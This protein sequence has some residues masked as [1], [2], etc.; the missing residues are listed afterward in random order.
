[1]M[2]TV[3]IESGFV[4]VMIAIYKPC[5]TAISAMLV[6]D[7]GLIHEHH[8]FMENGVC[9]CVLGSHHKVLLRE[10]EFCTEPVA[11]AT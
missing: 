6:V 11:I 8:W 7:D 9:F 4:A 5:R 3:V 2:T 10:W 1:M